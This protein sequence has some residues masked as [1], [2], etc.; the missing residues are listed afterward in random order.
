MEKSK[1]KKKKKRE[2]EFQVLGK[3][4]RNP[5]FSI[6][7]MDPRAKIKIAF[8]IWCRQEICLG[9]FKNMFGQAFTESNQFFRYK[10]EPDSGWKISIGLRL[11]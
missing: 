10:I 1:R 5:V 4:R 3:Q 2:R 6:L 8:K 7:K 9:G 11:E